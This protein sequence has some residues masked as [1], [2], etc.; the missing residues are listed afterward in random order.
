MYA[1]ITIVP[2]SPYCRVSLN[3]NDGAVELKTK[4]NVEFV[5]KVHASNKSKKKV[6]FNLK[7]GV[8]TPINGSSKSD[9]FSA[10]AVYGEEVLNRLESCTNLSPLESIAIAVY[11]GLRQCGVL[12]KEHIGEWVKV[13]PILSEGNIV[14]TVIISFYGSYD[15]LFASGERPKMG[16]S[17]FACLGFEYSELRHSL[18]SFEIY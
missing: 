6:R 5:D 8:F 10:N 1:I 12:Y 9:E 2:S 14:H 3:A 13:E 4:L 18:T 7:E 16:A 17:Y 15:E 11:R